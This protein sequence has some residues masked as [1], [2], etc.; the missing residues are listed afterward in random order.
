LFCSVLTAVSILEAG[1]SLARVTSAEED[2]RWVGN[3]PGGVI[4]LTLSTVRFEGINALIAEG[5]VPG[6]SDARY[7][8]GLG[9]ALSSSSAL[10]ASD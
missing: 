4:I 2:S 10:S 7:K 1:E 9:A 5:D 3:C 8:V 6:G